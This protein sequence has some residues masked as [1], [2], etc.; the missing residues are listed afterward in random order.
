[1]GAALFFPLFLALALSVFGLGRL[2]PVQGTDDYLLGR[3]NGDKA[4][5]SHHLAIAIAMATA[6]TVIWQGK[7][8]IYRLS[9]REVTQASTLSAHV[10]GAPGRKKM[11]TAAPFIVVCWSPRQPN[12]HMGAEWLQLALHTASGPA[13]LPLDK[14][15][16][17]HDTSGANGAEL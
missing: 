9:L 12:G 4:N 11:S 15:Q 1:M 5:G 16:V 8:S 13:E 17:Q 10:E 3:G 6:V 2:K 14:E 7:A